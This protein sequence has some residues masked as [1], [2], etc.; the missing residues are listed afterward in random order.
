MTGTLD[1]AV[2]RSTERIGEPAV[3]QALRSTAM[4]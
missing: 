2:E 4:T 1:L 3:A